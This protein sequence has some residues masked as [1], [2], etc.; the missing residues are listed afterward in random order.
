[1]KKYL[2]MIAL[3]MV[4][5]VIFVP[6]AS[7]NPDGLEKVAATFGVEEH[8]PL[9]NGLMADYSIGAIGNSYLS[10]VLAGVFGTFMV[11]LATF[12]LGRAIA[13]KRRAVS[14]KQ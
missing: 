4:F 13:P 2:G 8:Q 11:L 12:L 3:I 9:W 1:L 6:F 10:T 14:D 7:S 5:L